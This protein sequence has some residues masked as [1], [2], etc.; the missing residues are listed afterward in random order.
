VHIL[1]NKPSQISDYYVA[2][3][4]NRA[5]AFVQKSNIQQAMNHLNK[6]TENKLKEVDQTYPDLILETEVTIP[7]LPNNPDFV[8]VYYSFLKDTDYNLLNENASKWSKIYYYLGLIASDHNEFDLV[9][10]FWQIAVNLSPEWSYFQIELA[11]FYLAREE[12][13]K[14]YSQM[15]YCQQ[16]HFPQAHCRQFIE[17]NIQTNSPE[18]IGSWE[19][20]IKDI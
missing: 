15:D 11:N 3:H 12:I 6:A 16:F 18:I 13:D 5:Q 8:E 14:A 4:L 19:I 9:V 7:A 2:Y 17:E 1:K 20:V 10:P